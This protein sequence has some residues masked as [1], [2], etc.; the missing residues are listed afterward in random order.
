M[1]GYPIGSRLDVRIHAGKAYT[2]SSGYT[3]FIMA[4]VPIGLLAGAALL[5]RWAR[6]RRERGTGINSDAAPPP[7][8]RMSER[9]F[10]RYMF[11]GR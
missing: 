5:T 3:Y 2:W 9:E 8:D 1:R 6:R 11:K 4:A 10:W 7:G